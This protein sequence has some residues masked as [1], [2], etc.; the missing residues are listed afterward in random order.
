MQSCSFIDETPPLIGING[1]GVNVA[2][3]DDGLDMM[4]EDLAPNFVR[5]PHE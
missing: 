3:I 1:T 5:L 2:I 4:S